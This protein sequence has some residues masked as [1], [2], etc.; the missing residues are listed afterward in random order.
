MNKNNTLEDNVPNEPTSHTTLA[1]AEAHEEKICTITP[2]PECT[3]PAI[4]ERTGAR[5]F[6]WADIEEDDDF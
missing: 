6:R 3:V 2:G 4:L 1:I 5:S